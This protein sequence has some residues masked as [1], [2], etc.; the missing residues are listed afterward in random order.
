MGDWKHRTF[1]PGDLLQG[2]SWLHPQARR[3]AWPGP[4]ASRSAGDG[5]RSR[6]PAGGRGCPT[7]PCTRPGVCRE[8]RRPCWSSTGSIGRG[9]RSARCSGARCTGWPPT[10]IAATTHVPPPRPTS[11]APGWTIRGSAALKGG[12]DRWPAE[13]AG[14]PGVRPP[15]DPRRRRGD[16]RRGRRS[17]R[18]TTARRSWSRWSCCWLTANFQDRLLLSLGVPLEEGGPLPPLRG[19]LRPRRRRRRPS[20][21]GLGPKTATGR[22]CRRWWTIPSGST[23]NSKSSGRTSIPASDRAAGSA[24]RPSRRS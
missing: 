16:R 14:G 7:G 20:P 24:C 19:P 11:D 15:D 21:D 1:L 2:C 4:R 12:P 8:P 22:P 23:W 13:R 17:C 6:S 10:P 9:T 18:R 3:M 5:S